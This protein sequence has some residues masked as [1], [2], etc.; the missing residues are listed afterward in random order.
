[1]PPK[2]HEDEVDISIEL[3]RKLVA[4]QFSMYIDRP[5]EPLPS[6][7]TDNR[8]LRLGDDLIVR[9]PRMSRAVSSLQK[10]ID[11]L[12]KLSAKIC[13]PVPTPAH[14][15]QPSCEYPFPWCIVPFLK[16]TSPS[17]ECLLDFPRAAVV[18]SDFIAGMQ[19]LGATDAPKSVRGDHVGVLDRAV[20]TNL[21]LLKP[22]YDI[23]ELLTVWEG[24]CDAPEYDGEA[25]WIH[26]DLHPGNLLVD[27]EKIVAIVDFG[28]SGV[29][30]PACD[31]MCA[32]T[33]LDQPSRAI[34]QE[35]LSA[36]LATWERAKGWAFSM[37][38][39]GYPYYRQTDPNFAAIAKRA[40]DEVLKDHREF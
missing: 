34:F 22:D 17:H 40:L 7:G 5:I 16:G 28:L 38:V 15:G 6:E 26:G 24:I 25:V 36:E 32:W 4:D 33:V 23:D 11:W 13:L 35:H 39:L 1:M 29:G 12:P 2:L 20:R 9:L 18:L 14:V 27:D 19:Q 21:P 30:D 8:M 31:L 37:G 10:E 3:V